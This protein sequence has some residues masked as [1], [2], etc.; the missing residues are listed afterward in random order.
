LR[1]ASNGAALL[2]LGLFDTSGVVDTAQYYSGSKA[3]KH[4]MIAAQ[5]NALSYGFGQ[6][7]QR[8][9]SGIMILLFLR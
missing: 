3:A 6:V 8:L 1:A 4:T 2:G 5:D 7:K 9:G